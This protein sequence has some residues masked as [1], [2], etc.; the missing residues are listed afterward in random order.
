MKNSV[1]DDEVSAQTQAAREEFL[2]KEQRREV[3][4][5][6]YNELERVLF[7]DPPASE[8]DQDTAIRNFH[9]KLAHA[10]KDSRER[11]KKQS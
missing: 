5:N 11:R 8:E 9:E 10:Y 7:S 1:I 3:L 4:R 2:R 6:S